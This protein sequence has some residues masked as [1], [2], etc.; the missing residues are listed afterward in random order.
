MTGTRHHK[1]TAHSDGLRTPSNA[2]PP[3]RPSRATTCPGNPRRDA[4]RSRRATIKTT[5]SGTTSSTIAQSL[6]PRAEAPDS[7]PRTT[8]ATIAPTPPRRT[9]EASRSGTSAR[10]RPTRRESI[11]K[12]DLPRLRVVVRHS[13]MTSAPTCP[14]REPRRAVHLREAPRRCS[15]TTLAGPGGKI[16]SGQTV[17]R[18]H[19]A[20]PSPPAAPSAPSSPSRACVAA[21]TR[22][23][24]MSA[25]RCPMRR[26][27]NTN[28][29]TKAVLPR[30][31]AG[32]A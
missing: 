18:V 15:R 12:T 13:R 25:H 22:R 19:D 29:A 30:G 8:R 32:E 23:R 6:R 3:P 1:V 28:T 4:R 16:P 10:R 14:R 31:A 24:T 26:P 5:T 27:S 7:R 21:R 11:T 17:A 2:R 9:V 20:R